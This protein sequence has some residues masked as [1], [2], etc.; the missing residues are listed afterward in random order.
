MSET[1]ANPPEPAGGQELRLVEPAPLPVETE[2]LRL[3]EM[4]RAAQAARPRF[5]ERL[6]SIAARARPVFALLIIL[7]I[8]A[9]LW[10]WRAPAPTPTIV[11][12]PLDYHKRQFLAALRGSGSNAPPMQLRADRVRFHQKALLSLGFL[13]ERRFVLP[14]GR[15]VNSHL[16]VSQL[17]GVNLDFTIIE[18][19]GKDLLV[20][21]AP[22]EDM[23]VWES[24]IN[25]P[26]QR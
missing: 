2:H 20:V 12:S 26:D 25:K 14:K 23:P 13:E 6:S 5:R 8:G 10:R 21:V 1:P 15:S 19:R 22:R 16:G 3:V 4:R 9:V 17:D 24:L 11:E 7:G 18:P